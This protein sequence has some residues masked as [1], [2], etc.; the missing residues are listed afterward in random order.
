MARTT[1]T[2]KIIT[3]CKDLSSQG[4]SNIMISKSLN[5]AIATLSKNR[6]LVQSIQEGKQ[7]LATRVTKSIL[8]SLDESQDRLFIAKRLNLFNPQI[9]IK[10]PSNAKEALNNL[11][12]AI[13]QYADG[14]INESQLRTI[15]AV[16][17][18]YVKAYEA[19]ELEERIQAL[20]KLKET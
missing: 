7:D 5:I 19:T 4:F 20:E 15:E 11:S 1:I 8:D 17:N 10:K 3:Q 9:N 6:K 16:T 2:D 14:E 13:K 12:T 18:S